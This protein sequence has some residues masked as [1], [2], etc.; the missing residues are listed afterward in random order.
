MCGPSPQ[1][2]LG[3]WPR[4]PR[5]QACAHAVCSA[6]IDS[7]IAKPTNCLVLN[8]L[9]LKLHQAKVVVDQ[10][11][12]SQSLTSTNFSYDDAAQRATVTFDQEMPASNKA[13]FAIDFEGIMNDQMAGFYRSK[14]MPTVPAAKSV[15][16]DGH[17][18]YML[19]TQF[20]SCD[21]RRA[22]PCFDEPNIKA[23]FDFEIEVPTDQ[24]AL[25]NMPVKETKPTKEGWHMVSFETSP[26]MS[27]YLLAWAVGDFEYLEKLTDRRYNG[28]QIPVRVYTTRGLKEQGRWAL[29]HAPKIIDFFSQIFD[30]DYPLPKSDLIAVHEF[31]H[32][33]MENWGLV[34]YRTTQV[35]F[36]E[37]TSDPRFR[38][39]VAYVVAHELAHQWF[40]NLVTM[41]WWDELW[42]NEGFATWVGWHAIDHLHPDWEVWAQFV[43]EGMETAF[44]SDGI[45]ASHPIHVPVRDALDIN[46]IFDAISYRKGCSAIRMLAN[47]LGID[48]FLKGVSNYLKAHAYGNAKTKAL[49]D[50]LGQ[51]S[52]KDVNA[53][54]DPWITK[55]GHPVVTVA[56]EPGQ[57][58]VRQNRFLS[59][60]DVQA[61][62][63]TTTWWI[64]LG[65]EGKKGVSGVADLALT[66]R[67][68]VIRDIDDEFY[69]LNSGATG[70][71]RVNYPQARL[72]KLSHQLGRL[73]PA[74]RITT[75]GSTADLSFAGESTAAN[76]LTFL[77]GFGGENHPLV[78]QQILDTLASIRSVFAED[79]A[80][81]RGLDSFTNKLI[82]AKLKELGW[83]FP[84]GENY[85]VG[86]LR[87]AL[88]HA[89]VTSRNQEYGFPK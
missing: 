12:G 24:V 78:W 55:I 10:V 44:Q 59:T 5:S 11:K 46:Q 49:W 88:I 7:Q 35:L 79:E 60:G 4:F 9:H 32:G 70:F 52:G 8:A 41:D 69:K 82:E 57:I 67:E 58:T 64:P 39:A 16:T 22:F 15:P 26:R 65:L 38:N 25:S 21:A 68:D 34:T 17:F 47:D 18:H 63:D 14:Y 86:L 13:A 36:D 23:T 54:M 30:I 19:S 3:S 81:K 28:K 56:E 85:L 80:V 75:I 73:S 61:D 31:T 72:Q 51:A 53:M 48:V 2:C 42:L 27:S 84:D 66:R 33:A 37:K 76:V 45:R 77:E 83:T 29:E 89:A 71:Y 6:R 50:A 87:K 20:E 43:N 40:G 1:P 62:E 74:D